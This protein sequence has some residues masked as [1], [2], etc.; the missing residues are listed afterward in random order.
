MFRA[1]S[2][3]SSPFIALGIGFAAFPRDWRKGNF[4]NDRKLTSF[5]QSVIEQIQNTSEYQKLQGNES[6]TMHYSSQTFPSQHHKNSVGSGILFG[7]N[8]MEIDPIIFINQDEGE[9]TGFY[10]LGR[11]LISQDGQIHNGVVSTILDEGLCSCGFPLLPSKKGV[12]AKLSIDFKNQIPPGST[13]ILRA[14]VKEAKGRKV[15]IHGDLETYPL[16]EGEQP[17]KIAESRCIL[18]EPKW[19]QYFSWLQVF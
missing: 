17:L 8:L 18:V 13:V 12:T 10:H 19:F 16:K 3:I 1:I 6:V 5:N 7:P 9:L 11:S 2:R 15:V 14:R 4:T